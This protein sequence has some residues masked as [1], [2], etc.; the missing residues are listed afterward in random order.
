[1]N[2]AEGLDG[3]AAL[4]TPLFSKSYNNLLLG[5]R[6]S[7]IK[8]QYALRDHYIDDSYEE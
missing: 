2:V 5:N 6:T 8:P 3:G 1:M 7:I 4:P